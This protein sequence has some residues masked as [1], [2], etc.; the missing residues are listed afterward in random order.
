MSITAG[1]LL[2]SQAGYT[3]DTSSS[4]IR[5]AG[6]TTAFAETAKD[7]LAWSQ[8]PPTPSEQKKYRQSTVHAPGVRIVHYGIVDD[9]LPE[10][11]FG[12]CTQ[13]G[14][15]GD[16][17][18]VLRSEPEGEMARWQMERKEAYYASNRR[19]PLGSTFVR[20]HKIPEGMGTDRPFGCVY[21][22]QE[23]ERSRQAA[24]IIFPTDQPP[25]LQ[26]AGKELYVKSHAAY[27]PG[28][29]R[30]RGYDW[31]A[32]GIHPAA[33][34]FGAVDTEDL[35]DGVKK[36]LQP[37]LDESQPHAPKVGTKI[38][39][40]YKATAGDLLGRPK[41]LGA[42]ERPQI[43]PDHTFGLHSMRH[44][45]EPG[46]DQVIQGSY[47][48][49]QQA[50]DADLGKSLREGWRNV[51]P[52]GKRFGVP[53]VRTDIPKPRVSSVA[54]AINYGSE[55]DALQLLRPPKS[56]ELGVNEEHYMA[57]RSRVEVRALISDAAVALSDDEFDAV[58]SMAANADGVGPE[59]ACLDT[60]FRARHHLLAQTISVPVPF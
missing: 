45:P 31:G 27:G 43:L 58:W 8:P 26:Y 25:E 9:A 4:F 50:P 56:V 18:P 6:T 44:G 10:G 59:T 22:G 49:A 39:Q 7:A 13:S 12:Q 23:L 2:K 46:V 60:F 20:G 3:G 29:Q 14:E 36:A 19:E 41:K 40:D 17:G 51:A 38:H 47:S 32:A 48:A 24:T 35:R 52:S 28:E 55:P 34:R 5:P 21:G 54:S 42:G 30:H 37:G 53:S 16:M 1:A 11:P 33:H 57:M 15:G